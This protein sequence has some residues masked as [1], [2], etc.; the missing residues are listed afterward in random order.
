MRARKKDE[1]SSA[2]PSIGWG[3]C[4]AAGAAEGG[5]AFDFDGFGGIRRD[6]ERDTLCS[7]NDRG[8]RPRQRSGPALHPPA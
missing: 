2:R 1:S 3:W 7:A 5:F 4:D 8:V 6:T